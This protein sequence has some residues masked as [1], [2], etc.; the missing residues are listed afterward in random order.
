MSPQTCICVWRERGCVLQQNRGL[1]SSIRDSFRLYLMD[2]WCKKQK[3]HCSSVMLSSQIALRES[4]VYQTES[5]S[6]IFICSADQ[7]FRC[8]AWKNRRRKLDLLLLIPLSV[9]WL[10]CETT[11]CF[12]PSVLLLPF[13]VLL[14]SHIMPSLAP[15]CRKHHL[16]QCKGSQV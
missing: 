11:L 5:M 1:I 14:L 16:E 13:M 6:M 3:Q 12:S 7:L 2:L 4:V 8:S 15:S 10:R 9:P